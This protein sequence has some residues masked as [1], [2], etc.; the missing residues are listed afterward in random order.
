MNNL[1]L[2]AN[3]QYLKN[4]CRAMHAHIGNYLRFI[5]R[6][7]IH[8]VS[9]ITYVLVVEEF[10]YG[11]QVIFLHKL[12]KLLFYGKLIQFKAHVRKLVKQI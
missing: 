9:H 1:F 4:F 10:T 11:L 5:I 3:V 12:F 8:Q 2:A 6:V 7:I